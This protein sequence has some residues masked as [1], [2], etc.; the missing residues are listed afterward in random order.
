MA[1]TT[2]KGLGILPEAP[3]YPF[4]TAGN[5]YAVVSFEESPSAIS[6]TVKSSPGDKIGTALIPPVTVDGLENG[7]SYTFTVIATNKF[8]QSHPSEQS[9]SI[10]PSIYQNVY[11]K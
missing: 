2:N 3:T 6:Y 4:A 10:T 7:T 8:G 1:K 9:N 5:G 11:K